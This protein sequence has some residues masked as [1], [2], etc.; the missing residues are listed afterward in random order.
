MGKTFRYNKNDSGCGNNYN[1][2]KVEIKRRK[3]EAIYAAK[4]RNSRS[5]TTTMPEHT[6]TDDRKDKV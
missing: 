5:V 6:S 3:L 1:N 4:L 2:S